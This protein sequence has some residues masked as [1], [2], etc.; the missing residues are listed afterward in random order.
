MNNL[1]L[2]LSMSSRLWMAVCTFVVAIYHDTSHFG[3]W[4]QIKGHTE[5]SGLL[6]CYRLQISINKQAD[7]DYGKEYNNSNITSMKGRKRKTNCPIDWS[8]RS[9]PPLRV[10]D[11]WYQ[12]N[13]SYSMHD[14]LFSV[15]ISLF[16][17]FYYLVKEY[18]K[19]EFPDASY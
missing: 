15:G 7:D 8:N 6:H 11:Y 17:F 14:V 10:P 5:F 12:A 16:F 2:F 3:D 1:P 19:M 4:L 18:S 9:T 13:A